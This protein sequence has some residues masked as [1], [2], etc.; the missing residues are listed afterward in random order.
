MNCAG[1]TGWNSARSLSR[2][3]AVDARE[4]APVAPFGRT[5]RGEGAAH[6]RAFDFE[7]QQ[8]RQAR[9]RR[10][11]PS[12]AP[13]ACGSDR[14]EQVQ[15]CCAG[16]R[17]MRRRVSDDRSTP[18]R[19]AGTALRPGRPPATRAGARPRH[20][21]RRPPACEAGRCGAA[22]RA[23][24]TNA[25]NGASSTVRKPCTTSAS[26]SSS[27]LSICGQASSRTCAIA[28]GSSLPMSCAVCRSIIGW[29][30]TALV[31]RSSAAPSSRKA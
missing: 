3:L 9:R 8:G 26:C 22:A 7:L 24:S 4:Q 15:A 5:G 17:A 29:V 11:S 30:L 27:A 10:S 28:C 2:V 31:R 19:S 21:A 12:G 14:A 1:G 16:S 13:S 18:A 25:G 6:H 20:T 23:S